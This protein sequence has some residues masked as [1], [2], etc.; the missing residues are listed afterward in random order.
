MLI[1]GGGFMGA[2]VLKLVALR[3]PRRVIVADTRAEALERARTMGA[4]H[5]IDVTA[6]AAG[7][8]GR[9]APTGCPPAFTRTMSRRPT[10]L[11]P[12]S[13]SR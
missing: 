13:P 8:G 5:T 6:R 1:V 4:T 11:A 3:G 2:L 7:R 12:T 9:S 10:R